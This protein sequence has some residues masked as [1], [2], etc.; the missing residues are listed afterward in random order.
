MPPYGDDLV[1][2][3]AAYRRVCAR[4][5]ERDQE[6]HDLQQENDELR[7]KVDALQARLERMTRRVYGAK[8]ERHHP[9][10]Q[11]IDPSWFQVDVD[12]PAADAASIGDGA[13]A[14]TSIQAA[15]APP[16]GATTTTSDTTA[17][18]TRRPRTPGSHPGRRRLP[19]NSE[20]VEQELTV[21]EHERL[22]EHG[23]P[24][25]LLGWRTSDKWDYR[26]G[27]Y[28]IRRFRRAI[29]GRPFSEAAD[30]LVADLP[31]MLIPRGAM[32][33]AAV[34]HTVVE[35]FADHLPLYRQAARAG[36]SGFPLSRSTLVNHVA[37]VAGAMAPI[38]ATLADQVRHAPYLHLDDTP[39]RLLDPGR[40]CTA[41]ARIWVYR[42]PDATVFRFSTSREGRHPAA[43]LEDYRGHI[44]ADGY[45]GHEGL[46]GLGKATHVACWAHARR[47]FSD[48]KDRYPLALTLV[49][50]IQD[51]YDIE[52]T[53]RWLSDADRLHLR[54]TSSRP[55]VARIGERL[56]AAAATRLPASDLG[57]AIDYTRKRW[58]QLTRFLDQG[59]L[60]IDNNAAENA[61][62]PWAVG[63]KNWLFFGSPAGGERA[64]TIATIIDNCRQQDLDPYRYLC[65]TVAALHA[66]RTD[67]P[68]LT[69][70][71]V[72]AQHDAGAA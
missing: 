57:T 69:P 46:Y 35:K 42:S 39:V 4:L 36:R 53:A 24:L 44:V 18:R 52:R 1:E 26:P 34:I 47:K 13:S 51:L 15:G 33:D 9:G 23:Q 21:P 60:P 65:D 55:I 70:Q 19:A 50:D 11:V 3:R 64:A 17:A 71:A 25:P 62:R 61:L 66:G 68:A 31:A 2:M 54:Q 63:R 14:A 22:D 30:R 28:L 40:G 10:Q 59:W 27:T 32:T 58:R 38:V 45:A 43:F 29:Y 67:Y 72:A 56:N 6:A 5:A 37:A 8:S 12:A 41:T 7:A 48:I 16:T 49:E 20:I